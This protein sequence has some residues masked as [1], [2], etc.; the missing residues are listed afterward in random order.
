M[1]TTKCEYNF[2]TYAQL[3][4]D[5]STAEI[6]HTRSNFIKMYY[7]KMIIIIAQIKTRI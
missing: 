2:S 1:Q 3:S 5:K 7:I 6:A 4:I